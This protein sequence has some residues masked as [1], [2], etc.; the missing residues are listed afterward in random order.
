MAP[1]CKSLSGASF[2]LQHQAHFVQDLSPWKVGSEWNISSEL[3]QVIHT[4][5]Q[6]VPLAW[7][8]AHSS[9][10]YETFPSER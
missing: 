9:G 8:G 6:A 7:T 3:L 4:V 5:L 1:P 2:R 10:A